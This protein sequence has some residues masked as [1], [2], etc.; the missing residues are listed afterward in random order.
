M[1]FRIHTNYHIAPLDQP[2]PEQFSAWV[3]AAL[4]GARKRNGEVCIA[5]VDATEG[6]ELNRQYRGKDYATNVLSFPAALPRGVRSDLLGD[7]VL[8][9]PVVADEALAQHKSCL[10]HYAHLSVH[11]TLHLLGFDHIDAADAECMEAMET[12]ILAKLGIANPY[13]E[14]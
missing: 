5:V 7:L 10:D 3:G 13:A 2:S 1:P 14:F 11:G 4:R 8:C 12:R 9:A 6:R